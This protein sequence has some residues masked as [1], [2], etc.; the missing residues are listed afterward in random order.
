MTIYVC[1]YCGHITTI[2]KAMDYHQQVHINEKHQLNR[3]YSKLSIGDVFYFQIKDTGYHAE[4][5]KI[6]NN[7]IVIED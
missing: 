2:K 3:P 5:I 1:G 6:N 7:T 4:V